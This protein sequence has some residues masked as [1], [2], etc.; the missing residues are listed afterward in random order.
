MWRKK[1]FLE[2]KIQVCIVMIKKNK[3]KKIFNDRKNGSVFIVKKKNENDFFKK[4]VSLT[5]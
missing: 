5:I 4:R 1:W 2:I 3:N